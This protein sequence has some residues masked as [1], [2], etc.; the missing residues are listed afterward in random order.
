MSK[1]DFALVCAM[2]D[3][4]FH[5]GLDEQAQVV[6]DHFAAEHG[7]AELRLELVITCPRD[8][9]SLLFGGRPGEV[10]GDYSC[11]TCMRS[12]TLKRSPLEGS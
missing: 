11:P 6:A 2:P 3:C 1:P 10:V 8:G 9:Q 5:P 12:Y 7:D 4:T